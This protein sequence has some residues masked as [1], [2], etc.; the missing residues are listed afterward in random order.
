MLRRKG[1]D[2]FEVN[3][4]LSTCME[5]NLAGA[6]GVQS[7]SKLTKRDAQSVRRACT[8]GRSAPGPRLLSLSRVQ[9]GRAPGSGERRETDF[10]DQSR[11]PS[12]RA[13]C[14]IKRGTRGQL[15]TETHRG[16]FHAYRGFGET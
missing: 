10:G 4:A 2:A 15:R 8:V 13:A 6:Y 7:R 5:K 14:D 16:S 12:V 9:S 3:H 1:S 11:F